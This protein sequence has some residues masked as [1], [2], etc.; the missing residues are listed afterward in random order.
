MRWI[1]AVGLVLLG[2]ACIDGET[3]TTTGSPT[4][5]P[6][7]TPTD[8]PKPQPTEEYVALSGV[9][10]FVGLLV[11]HLARLAFGPGHRV[12]LPASAMLGAGLLLLA[13]LLARTLVLPAELP[14]GVL[15]S[16]VGGP[17]FL[18]MLMRRLR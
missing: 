7:D 6:T 15:T 9:I 13:D 17:L 8:T 18:A 3:D 5:A 2:A 12:L 16:L 1:P 14:I 4:D 11:P 10:G